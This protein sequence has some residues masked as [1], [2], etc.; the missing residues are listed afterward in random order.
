MPGQE[1]VDN[2]LQVGEVARLV[3]PLG[4]VWLAVTGQSPRAG[5][6][7]GSYVRPVAPDLVTPTGPLRFLDASISVAGVASRAT[8]S[9]GR[10]SAD[11]VDPVVAQ[12]PTSYARGGALLVAAEGRAPRRKRGSRPG[13]PRTRR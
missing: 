4:E 3:T 5:W 12:V 13:R 10:R 2:R 1:A 6:T 11:P 7:G 9:Q 8:A